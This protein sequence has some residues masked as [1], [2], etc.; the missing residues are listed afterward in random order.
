MKEIKRCSRCILPETFP[1]ITFNEERICNFC[2]SHKTVSVLG[3]AKLKGI[4]DTKKG[5]FYDCVVPVSG[6]KDST[7]VLY[8][9][10]KILKLKA[11]AVNYDS[12]FLSDLAKENMKNACRILN[13][14]LV[15]VKC[16][17]ENQVK[18][19][20]ET[21][22][23]SE[24]LGTF[25]GTCGN[26][27]ANIRY[28]SAYVAKENKVPFILYGRSPFEETGIVDSFIYNNNTFV[29][30][31]VK[32]N[33]REIM[34]LLFHII[35]YCFHSLQQIIQMKIPIRFRFLPIGSVPFPNKE[36]RFI[37]F[38]DYIQWDLTNN[39]SILK[40]KLGWRF[41]SNHP[42]RFDCVLHC[43]ANHR[44]LQASGIS[45]DGF[46]YST[47]IRENRVKRN[48]AI[49]WERIV[50]ERIEEEYPKTIEKIGLKDFK[51]QK[52]K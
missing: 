21:L 18:M 8:Y 2:L 6:G 3:E 51:M 5:K 24:I 1:K 29:N 32:K 34:K 31:I 4:L 49:L 14:P 15:V 37:N 47:M 23:I 36:I 30:K 10:V 19:I 45:Q 50:R 28:V 13:V 16:D 9:A 27:E 44:W 42:H 43:F 22:Y 48:D 38:Y 46:D 25:F 39:V 20:K 7:Y 33:I 52:I 35:K 17:Y 41:P 11:I 40:E 26:C 12:G